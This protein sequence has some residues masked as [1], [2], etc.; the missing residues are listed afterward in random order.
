MRVGI[1]RFLIVNV[2]F[3]FAMSLGGD[4]AALTFGDGKFVSHGFISH[5]TGVQLKD[6]IWHDAVIKQ[7]T[8][9][10]VPNAEQE[11]GNLSRCKT[12]LQLENEWTP[13]SDLKFVFTVRGH[14]DAK[15]DIDDD[16]EDLNG[17]MPDSSD[18]RATPNGGSIENDLDL[19]EAYLIYEVGD[20]TIR[21]GKQ[22]IIWG[23]SDLIRI[24]DIINPLDYSPLLNTGDWEDLRIP[25][26]MIDILYVV[27]NS[28]HKYQLEVVLNPEDYRAN[29]FAPYG[30]H[31]YGFPGDSSFETVFAGLG[32]N[33]TL[34]G[35]VTGAIRGGLPEKHDTDNFSGGMR[36]RG[37][38]GAWDIYLFDYYQR[39]Q[40][41]TLTSTPVDFV[42]FG[43]L[44]PND[45][46]WGI[47]AEYPWINTLGLT[48]NVF[49]N[50]TN[51]VF[52][53][54][55]GYTFDE[56]FTA[57]IVTPARISPT[58]G[59][60][61]SERVEKDTFQYMLG[62]DR[63]TMIPFL[64]P[65]KPFFISGQFIGK[66]VFGY[67]DRD[68]TKP[69]LQTFAGTNNYED[70]SQMV[71]L[72]INT[73]Y[74]DAKLKPEVAFVWDINGHGGFFRPKVGYEPTYS[75]RFE[76]GLRNFLAGKEHYGQIGWVRDADE[77]YV[78]VEYKF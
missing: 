18:L 59:I 9:L 53:G 13:T 25:Q 12:T 75:W 63:P 50:F 48:F 6:R 26:R 29:T 2:A 38:F 70:E 57:G 36:V 5:E 31:Y 10:D 49:D 54:E 51:T 60:F 16:L 64:N 43:T 20:F 11:K 69:K 37:V 61:G 76:I 24:A 55:C 66:T 62:F 56:P 17:N 77:V 14:Y 4:A 46:T 44:N 72:L 28:P 67:D 73:E 21:A 41:P 65:L 32:S 40:N 8:G 78:A 68:A 19:R 22:Q 7:Q 23:E 27:P 74:M 15:Y 3:V 35:A 39:A 47:Q 58:A 33:Q 52:R 45:D 71:T 42:N 30:E 1:V 34:H